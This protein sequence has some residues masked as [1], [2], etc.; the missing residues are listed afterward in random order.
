[1]QI[2]FVTEASNLRQAGD[3]IAVLPDSH[4]FGREETM[5]AWVA[6]GGAA[7]AFPNPQFS[8]LQIPGEPVDLNLADPEL[9]DDTHSGQATATVSAKSAWHVDMARLTPPEATALAEPGAV[10]D[11]NR[12]RGRVLVRLRHDD[13]GLPPRPENNGDLVGRH[14]NT[15]VVVRPGKAKLR[16]RPRPTGTA[17]T[18]K[19]KT[20]PN[21]GG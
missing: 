20:R 3:I 6:A 5:A 15:K 4:A 16:D 12:G 10:V 11:L 8:V 14:A 17:D 19:V 9:T 21:R 7:D 18:K 2:L 1:M 13:S